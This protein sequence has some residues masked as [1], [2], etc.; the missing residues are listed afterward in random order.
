M[1]PAGLAGRKAKAQREISVPLV[2]RWSR[3]QRNIMGQ[4]GRLLLLWCKNPEVTET[5][6]AAS[7]L[8]GGRAEQ[9]IQ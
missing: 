4:V 3:A 8:A 1:T 9:G 2:D 6:A 7:A 5:S